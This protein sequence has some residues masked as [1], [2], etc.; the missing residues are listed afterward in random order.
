VTGKENNKNC[1]YVGGG[2]HFKKY[3]TIYSNVS[4]LSF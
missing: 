2:G 3:Y 4:D 1:T